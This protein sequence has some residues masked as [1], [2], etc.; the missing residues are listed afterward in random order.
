MYIFHSSIDVIMAIIVD[1]IIGGNGQ[2][3]VVIVK[4]SRKGLG[5]LPDISFGVVYATVTNVK[6]E[7]ATLIV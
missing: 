2:H 7:V 3:V 1:G 6:Q 4:V 5:N